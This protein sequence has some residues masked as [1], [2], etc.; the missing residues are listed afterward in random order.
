MLRGFD[1]GQRAALLISECQMAVL[2]PSLALF[3]GL[4]EQVAKRGIVSRIARLAQA[5]REAK[6]PVI[7]L[8]VAHRPG[9][10]DLPRT[11]AIIAGSTKQNRMIAG[12]RDVE[13]VAEL[14]PQ[15]GDILHSRSFSLVAFHGTDLD[16]TLRNMGVETVVPVGVST[17]VAISGM[18][19]CASDLGYQVVV[20]EDC[21]AGATAESHE[22]IVANLLPLY[23]TLSDSDSVIQAIR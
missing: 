5:F 17:N 9:Y 8:H 20:P 10:I 13:A 22:F 15:E 6:L 18:S 12:S 7:H 21:I 2:D 19:L 1:K 16:A 14:Q 4:A 11:S 23:S 3:Q